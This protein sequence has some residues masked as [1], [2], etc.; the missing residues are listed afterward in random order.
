M[1]GMGAISMKMP[2]YIGLALTSHEA[3]LTCEAKFSS[4][5]FPG[6]SVSPQ[7]TDQDIGILSNEAEP[8]YI[9]V[10]DGGGAEITVYHDNPDATLIDTWTEW[11]IA[12]A[13][14]SNAGLVLTDISK[15]AIGFGDK[16]NPQPGGSGL[17]YFDDIRLYLPTPEP[18]PVP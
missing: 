13:D 15:L 11:N 9:T 4:V 8:M 7:W 6:T 17:M 12:L 5:S 2:V 1:V 3:D 18:E 16:S 14:F 10:G